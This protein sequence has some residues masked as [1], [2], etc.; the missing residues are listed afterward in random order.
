MLNFKFDPKKYDY[1]LMLLILAA[2]LFGAYMVF[3]SSAIMADLRWA[4]PYKFFVKYLIFSIIGFGGMCLTAFL[5]NYKLYQKYAKYIYILTFVLLLAVLIFGMAKGG[6]KRWINIGFI[7]FQPSEIAKIAVIIFISDYLARRKDFYEK[8]QT[9]LVPV[10]M[11]FVMIIPI[12]I[13]PDLGTS[14]L[15]FA[16]SF[17]L[18]F[19]AGIKLRWILGLLAAGLSFITIEIIRKP[20]RMTRYRV[21][22]DSV[23]NIDKLLV[24]TGREVEQVK[25]SIQALGSG[26][27]FGKGLGNGEIKRAYLSEPHTDFI[28]AI[29]GEELGFVRSSLVLVFFLFLLYKGM[30]IS[31]NAPD[32]FSRFLA[33]GITLT[34]VYQALINLS[35]AVGNIPAKGITLPFISSGGS[36]LIATMTMAGILINLSQY[37]MKKV[38]SGK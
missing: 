20:Y 7:P 38:K 14:T 16:V 8:W 10:A 12:A 22:L 6:S 31:K 28:F 37:E 33:L 24:S 9:T 32:D 1:N 3:S 27:L 21:Y 30:Q 34:I 5:I 35:V 26:G 17:S 18:L 29:I 36:S 2:V 25:Q 13:S 15:I 23:F 19:C 4:S 11:L